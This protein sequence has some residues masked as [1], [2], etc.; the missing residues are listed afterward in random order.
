MTT[1]CM[2]GHM[3]EEEVSHPLYL[4]RQYPVRLLIA[5]PDR[6]LNRAT[7]FFRII[8]AIPIFIVVVAV[9]GWG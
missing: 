8:V 5:Y 2:N 1:V 9:S 4:S 3:A 6:D 7:T